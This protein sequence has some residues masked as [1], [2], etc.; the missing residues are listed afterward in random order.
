[1]FNGSGQAEG[2]YRPDQ[3]LCARNALGGDGRAPVGPGRRLF[4]L[5]GQ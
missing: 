4:E 5:T 1:M 2:G 3:D